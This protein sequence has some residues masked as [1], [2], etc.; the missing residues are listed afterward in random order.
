MDKLNLVMVL[1]EKS[2]TKVIKLYHPVGGINVCT[3]FNVNPFNRH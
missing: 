2:V 1:E 3:R